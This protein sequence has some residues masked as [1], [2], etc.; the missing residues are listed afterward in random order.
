MD[1][2]A[3]IA[4]LAEDPNATFD[5]AELAL[6][7]AREEYPDLDVEAYLGELAGMAREA[8][9]YLG[10]TLQ[11]QVAGLSRY[12]FHEMGYRGNKQDYYDPRNSYLNQV[13]DLRTGIP[14]TLSVL[15][16]ALGQRLGITIAGIGLPGHFIVKAVDRERQIIFDPF[17]GGR[18]LTFADCENLVR[19]VTGKPFEANC[20][21][22]RGLPLGQIVARLLTNL[23]MI[24][25]KREEYAKATR[26]ISRLWQLSPQ[27]QRERRDLGSVL[28]KLGRVGES[29]DHLRAYLASG[30]AVPDN[31]NIRELLDKAFAEVCKWN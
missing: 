2:N 19:H 17:H 14:I 5:V 1:L 25:L 24:Y 9:G 20:A 26:V 28:L 7:L 13:M 8:R 21:S 6:S 29:I 30:D 27:D 15:T 31:E 3:A 10:S 12:L 23:K 11:C 4:A 16:M 22:L 18:E